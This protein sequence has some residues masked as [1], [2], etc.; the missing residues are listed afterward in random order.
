MKTT[1]IKFVLLICF[2]TTSFVLF[3][4]SKSDKLFDTFKNKSGVTYFA[5]SNSI[6]STFNID[7]GSEG[8]E[9]KGDLQEIR[10]MSYNPTKGSLSGTEFLEKASGLLPSAYSLLQ[11]EDDDNNAQIWM[12]GN[13]RKISEFQVFIR[14]SNPEGS[15]FLVSFLG[16]FEINDAEGVRQMGLNLSLGD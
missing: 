2:V 14:N 5:Y 16:D 7:L 4:Q 10:F 12:L 9:I 11:M 13:K 8:N 6:E 3:A 1:T 15:C